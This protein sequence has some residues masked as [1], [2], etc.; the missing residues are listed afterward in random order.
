MI[1]ICNKE[2][3]KQILKLSQSNY[4][5][6]C[7][8]NSL[9]FSLN[10]CLPLGLYWLWHMPHWV[11]QRVVRLH[12]SLSLSVCL[13]LRY[14]IYMLMT[15]FECNLGQRSLG[16]TRHK[17]HLLRWKCLRRATEYSFIFP[18]KLGLK[19]TLSSMHSALLMRCVKCTYVESERMAK[20]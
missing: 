17:S 10:Y 19:L 7:A 5:S 9:K 20:E 3:A 4:I 11:A 16:A 1:F 2:L 14:F 15:E 13:D 12:L 18:T 8:E 6:K